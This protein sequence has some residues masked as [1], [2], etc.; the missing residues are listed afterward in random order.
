[1]PFR[2]P[3]GHIGAAFE[4]LRRSLLQSVDLTFYQVRATK[5][6]AD[7]F[8]SERVDFGIA[9]DDLDVTNTPEVTTW[10]YLLQMLFTV[11]SRLCTA[12]TARLVVVEAFQGRVVGNTNSHSNLRALR[13]SGTGTDATDVRY[14][15]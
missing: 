8:V 5:H 4:R 12:A 2:S 10:L 14:R 6:L 7:V 9:N 3:H 1:M 13:C 11:E 15:S